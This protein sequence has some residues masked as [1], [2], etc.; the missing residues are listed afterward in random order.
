MSIRARFVH[1][2]LIARD[3]QLLSRFYCDVF[4]CH[5]VPPERHYSGADLERGTGVRGSELHGV[6]LRLPGYDDDAPTL[7]IYTYTRLQ[8]GTSPTVNRP[9]FGHIAFC[10]DDV[11]EARRAVLA[12]GGGV[13]GEVV[14]LQIATGTKVTWCY[15]K[16]PEGNIIELQSW[17]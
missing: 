6:H 17:A 12:A 9:G 11:P 3:W 7:E 8:E 16:D 14:T 15:M 2:N 1:T 5:P 10:V 13:V 4:G